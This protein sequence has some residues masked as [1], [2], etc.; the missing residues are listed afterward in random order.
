MSN[1][2]QIQRDIERTRA[3]LSTD[4]DRLTEKVSPGRVVGRRVDRVKGG[5]TSLK[6]RVMGA[7]PSTDG[8]KGSLGDATSTVTDAAGNAPAAVR[9]QTQ[10]NPLAAGLVAFG[11]GV[12]A[13]SLLPA[14][15]QEQQLATKAQDR[16]GDLAEPAKAKAKELA[17]DLREPVQNS[18]QEIKSTVT[19]AA[20]ETADQ[21]R[22]SVDDVRAPLQS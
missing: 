13:A 10:G 3:N 19:D 9:R 2:E 17:D 18:V 20:G 11:V 4:V 12:I 1:P 8:I 6:D 14:T 7:T 22:S 5:A 16:A 15:Q 21:A